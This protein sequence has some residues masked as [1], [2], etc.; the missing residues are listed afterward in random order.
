M[1]V[2]AQS[3]E[4]LVGDIIPDMAAPLKFFS[5]RT[6]ESGFVDNV[7]AVGGGVSVSFAPALEVE[8]L[9]NDERLVGFRQVQSIAP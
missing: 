2:Y 9:P 3:L 4:Q 1:I 5:L 6:D 8:I 7:V